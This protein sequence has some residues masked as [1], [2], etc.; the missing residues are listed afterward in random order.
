MVFVNS[1]YHDVLLIQRYVTQRRGSKATTGLARLFGS[2]ATSCMRHARLFRRTPQKKT[3]QLL[4]DKHGYWTGRRT[5]Q[6]IYTRFVGMSVTDALKCQTPNCVTLLRWRPFHFFGVQSII[7]LKIVITVTRC[8]SAKKPWI[9][10]GSYGL[11]SE[12]VVTRCVRQHPPPTF[13]CEAVRVSAIT[14]YYG[15]WVGAQEGVCNIN[16]PITAV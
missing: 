10:V 6:P 13:P 12:W 1:T 14:L 2:Y 3:N 4:Q 7:C 5:I 11:V 16:I 15:G 9:V 8:V